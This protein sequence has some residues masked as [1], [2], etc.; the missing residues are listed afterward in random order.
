[1][2]PGILVLLFILGVWVG[3]KKYIKETLLII[4]WG[5]IPLLAVAEF[6]KVMTVRYI[7]FTFPFL[8][9]IA[10]LSLSLF[11]EKFS[12][13]NF[14][15]SYEFTLKRLYLFLFLAFLLQSSYIDYLL[16]VKP[17]AANLPRSERSGYFEEWTAG[18][19]IKEASEYIRNVYY[20]NP[21]EKIV[22]GTEGSFG[23]LPDGLQVYLNDIPEITVIGVGLDLKSVPQSLVES[24]NYGNKTFLLVND[25][26][27]KEDYNRLDLD[28]VSTYP[29]AYRKEGTKEYE[30]S[31]PREVLYLFEV[32]SSS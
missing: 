3:Y 5:I 14:L 28:L 17:Q 19:G 6:S 21:A 4:S 22:V 18:Y 31:G 8:F 26:R 27:L 30:L 24:V 7:Y 12:K 11:L 13:K 29:K 10:A 15:H 23:T 25:S 16:I 20:E 2:G 9:I 32:K 1:M